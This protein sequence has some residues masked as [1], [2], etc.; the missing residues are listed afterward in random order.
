MSLDTDF[1]RWASRVALSI[2]LMIAGTILVGCPTPLGDGSDDGGAGQ[3][4]S[5][6]GIVGDL[7][8]PDALALEEGAVGLVVDTRQ[9]FRRG[10]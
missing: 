3:D 4:P 8:G 10:Y 1:R 9:M 2:A 6:D 7:D 5:T